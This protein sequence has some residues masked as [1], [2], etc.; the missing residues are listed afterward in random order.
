[1]KVLSIRGLKLLCRRLMKASSK[2]VYP[3]WR[4]AQMCLVCL[5]SKHSMTAVFRIN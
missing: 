1:M 4:I 2:G 5:P 3:W